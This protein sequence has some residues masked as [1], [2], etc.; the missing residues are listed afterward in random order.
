M[1]KQDR[2]EQANDL[3]RVISEGGRRF[4]RYKGTLARFELAPSGHVFY[5]DQYTNKRIYTHY[6]HG[7]S[8]FTNGG[9]LQSLCYLLLDFI[10]LGKPFEYQALGPWGYD[11]WGYGEYMETVRETARKYDMIP[12]ATVQFGG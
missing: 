7:W 3:L 6:R 9:T 1:S 12:D 10:R 5:F 8:G 2:I 4:F 11:H